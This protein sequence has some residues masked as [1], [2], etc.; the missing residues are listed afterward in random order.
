MI[1]CDLF[2]PILLVARRIFT[3]PISYGVIIRPRHR[4]SW[5]S[6]RTHI[7]GAFDQLLPFSVMASE[8]PGTV[9]LSGSNV[10]H[11]LW[12]AECVS[13][14]LRGL[15]LEVSESSEHWPPGPRRPAELSSS[16][17]TLS[18]FYQCTMGGLPAVMAYSRQVH[19]PCCFRTS[20]RIVVIIRG[21]ATSTWGFMHLPAKLTKHRYLTI[22]CTAL[23]ARPDHSRMF[24]RCL[25]GTI[26]STADH[27]FKW[28]PAQTLE[29]SSGVRARTQQ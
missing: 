4:M 12:Y 28:I 22:V 1:D 8:E 16:Y 13:C 9:G 7:R 20:S 23:K 24:L 15:C 29:G 10:R 11:A 14:P 26:S 17:R 5:L 25:Q 19:T 27:Q 2:N 6:A 3:R 18:W 21:S